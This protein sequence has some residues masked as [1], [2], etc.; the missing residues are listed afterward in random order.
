MITIDGSGCRCVWVGGG[1]EGD[2]QAFR[3]STE[4]LGEHVVGSGNMEQL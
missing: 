3:W 1:G 2:L 4:G